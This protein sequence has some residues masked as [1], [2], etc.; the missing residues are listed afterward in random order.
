MARQGMFVVLF[1]LDY[2]P[3]EHSALYGQGMSFAGFYL[4]GGVINDK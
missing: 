3:Q 4:Q 2:Y 1:I